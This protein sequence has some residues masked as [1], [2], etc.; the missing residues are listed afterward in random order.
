MAD[1]TESC[2]I[3]DLRSQEMKFDI[4]K[5]GEKWW[6]GFLEIRQLPEVE[7]PKLAYKPHLCKHGGMPQTL[8]KAELSGDFRC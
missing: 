7:G 1:S 5:V 2:S 8:K 3:T 6:G 4:A